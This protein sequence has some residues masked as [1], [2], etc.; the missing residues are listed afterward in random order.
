MHRQHRLREESVIMSFSKLVKKRELEVTP[1]LQWLIMMIGDQSK[2]IS[3]A[4]ISTPLKNLISKD[5]CIK[6]MEKSSTQSLSSRPMSSNLHPSY[7]KSKLKNTAMSLNFSTASSTSRTL[8][9]NQKANP[10]L[11]SK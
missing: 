10:S 3:A 4:N 7:S 1:D 6:T 5:S 8:S 2:G 11:N 9:T